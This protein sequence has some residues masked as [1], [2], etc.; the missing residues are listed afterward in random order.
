MAHP[1]GIMLAYRGG[2]HDQSA[3]TYQKA[4][5]FHRSSGS[6]SRT[7]AQ[8]GIGESRSERPSERTRQGSVAEQPGKGSQQG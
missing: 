3:S 2:L 4:V 7:F 6:G 1:G 8:Q 5:R